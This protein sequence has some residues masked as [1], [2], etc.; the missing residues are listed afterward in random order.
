MEIRF[1]DEEQAKKERAAIVQQMKDAV[2]WAQ[3]ECSHRK[4][5]GLPAIGGQRM[6]KGDYLF[7]CLNCNKQWDSLPLSLRVPMDIIGGVIGEDTIKVTIKGLY[8]V[9]VDMTQ[10]GLPADPEKMDIADLE[11]AVYELSRKHQEEKEE[12]W[13]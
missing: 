13:D 4:V 1:M 12:I 5:N 2:E 8:K 9:G 6:E 3:A 10:F 7:L 11:K